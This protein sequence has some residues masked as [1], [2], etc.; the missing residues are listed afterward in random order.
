[1]KEGRR[2]GRKEPTHTQKPVQLQK[3]KTGERLGQFLRKTSKTL[4]LCCVTK[5]IGA[6]L[7]RGQT[8]GPGYF[9]RV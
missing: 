1:M 2:D 5:K 6:A 7:V 9:A 3:S 4:E 8:R